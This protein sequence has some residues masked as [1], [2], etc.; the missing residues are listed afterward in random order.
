MLS[1]KFPSK[2][3]L[4]WQYDLLDLALKSTITTTKKGFL[5]TIFSKFNSK[6]LGKVSK[7]SK[8]WLGDLIIDFIITDSYYR[9]Q[10]IATC[11]RESSMHLVCHETVTGIS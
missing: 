10:S 5:W 1:I 4:S 6:F 3:D 2:V 9:F 7:S 11:L 8:V